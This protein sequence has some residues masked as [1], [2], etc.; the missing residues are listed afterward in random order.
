MTWIRSLVC[1]AVLA[2]F[3][4]CGSQETQ[5]RTLSGKVTYKGKPLTT[6]SMEFYLTGSDVPVRAYISREGT[7]RLSEVLVGEYK[8]A[9]KVNAKSHSTSGMKRPGTPDPVPI[10]NKY[11]NTETSGLM[12]KVQE[13]DTTFDIDLS[14]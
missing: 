9:I 7:Y 2:S 11:A 4:G 14:D 5:R 3:I 8:L 1:L 13:K 12:A 6:G 10:P